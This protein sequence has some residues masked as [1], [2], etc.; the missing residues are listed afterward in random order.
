MMK[1]RIIWRL[2]GVLLFLLLSLQPIQAAENAWFTEPEMAQLYEALATF[3]GEGIFA[4][5][6]TAERNRKL[7]SAYIKGYD[8]YARYLSREEYSL[9]I[10]SLRPAYS[11]IQMELQQD[12][13]GRYTCEPFAGGAAAEAGIRRGDKL[14]AVND[15]S[16]VGREPF[17]VAG[18]TRGPA[19]TMVTLHIEDADGSTKKIPI[20]RAA[21]RYGSVTREKLGAWPMLRIHR[22]T[23][24]TAGELRHLLTAPPYREQPLILDLRNNGGGD[25]E[26]GIEAVK[27]FLP[28]ER[29]VV[30]LKTT[31]MDIVRKSTKTPL[32]SRAAP[33]I[34]LQNRGTASAAELFIGSLVEN[35]VA[36]SVGTTTQGKGVAQ[37]FYPLSNGDAL[38][39]SY[40]EIVLPGGKHYH[41]KGLAPIA[42]I[43]MENKTE[44]AI[45]TAY[46]NAVAGI[47]KRYSEKEGGDNALLSKGE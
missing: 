29:E 33:V 2:H 43:D 4:P 17:I 16:V 38:L 9:Y 1:R 20:T 32:P 36:L 8:T 15:T 6:N 11:G 31:S 26:S 23:S 41:N 5:S 25:M 13:T 39:L 30:T 3:Y 28:A 27:L 34:L 37:H 42:V 47:F 46:T 40:A 21:T 44:P 14:V 45:T 19:G 7:V 35:G 22:F 12:D 18:L 10:N 24:A